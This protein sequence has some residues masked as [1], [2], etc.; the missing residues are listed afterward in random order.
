MATPSSGRGSGRPAPGSSVSGSATKVIVLSSGVR[1]GSTGRAS[2]SSPAGAETDADRKGERDAVEEPPGR[3]DVE[4]DHAEEEGRAEDRVPRL[5]A[6]RR[7]DGRTTPRNSSSSKTAGAIAIAAT[8]MRASSG[9][10]GRSGLV[11]ALEGLEIPRAAGARRRTGARTTR[12]SPHQKAAPRHEGEPDGPSG[13]SPETEALAPGSPERGHGQEGRERRA[14][15]PR[16]IRPRR[17]PSPR[18]RKPARTWL[19][20]RAPRWPGR[21]QEAEGEWERCLRNGPALDHGSG[22]IGSLS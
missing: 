5:R 20:S 10:D 3:R 14:P 18:D 8:E 15:S 11:E 1:P 4:V 13:D 16:A 6:A 9:P 21:R 2:P 19:P 17:R 7:R 22:I 12:G